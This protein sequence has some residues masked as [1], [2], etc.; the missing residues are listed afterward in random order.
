[1]FTRE[2]LAMRLDL[3]EAR[4]QVTY[5]STLVQLFSSAAVSK[6][7]A[8]PLSDQW[9]GYRLKG[10]GCCRGGGSPKCR[11]FFVNLTAVLLLAKRHILLNFYHEY[12]DVDKI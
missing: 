4:V 11:K 8:D 6:G 2:E 9:G 7:P 3:T 12:D 5:I 10:M 1:V